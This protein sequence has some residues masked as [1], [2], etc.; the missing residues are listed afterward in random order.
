MGSNQW[1][2]GMGGAPKRKWSLNTP[3]NKSRYLKENNKPKLFNSD[4]YSQ[5]FFLLF[6]TDPP[7][8]L[9]IKKSHKPEYSNKLKC[10]P[11]PQ[12]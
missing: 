11:E 8:V 9:A 6:V 3:K 4:T 12:V 10:Q 5:I 7:M 1:V 2:K